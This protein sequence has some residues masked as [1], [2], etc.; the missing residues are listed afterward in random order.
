MVAT[1][2]NGHAPVLY[3][4]MGNAISSTGVVLPAGAQPARQEN[5]WD[6]VGRVGTNI[7]SGYITG[8]EYN[9]DL[10]GLKAI[11]TYDKMWR[12]DGQVHSSVTVYTLPLLRAEW[13]VKPASEGPIDVA[14]AQKVQDN[15]MGGLDVPWEDLLW[16]L[17]TGMYVYGFELREKVW[18]EPDEEGLIMLKKLAPRLQK[19]I[20]RWYPDEHDELASV[21][22]RAWRPGKPDAEGKV[23]SG[24]FTPVTIPAEKLALFTLN[25]IGNNFQGISLLRSA[26]T[27]WFYK[28]KLMYLDGIRIERGQGIPT[29][30]APAN[31]NKPDMDRAAEAL[32]SYHAH[33]KNYLLFP[34]GWSVQ[35]LGMGSASTVNPKV[36][37]DYHDLQIARAVLAQFLNLSGGGSQALSRDHS[38]FF[39]M[40]LQSV[41]QTVKSTVNKQVIRP[42]VDLNWEVQRYPTLEVTNLDSRDLDEMGGSLSNLASAGLLTPSREVENAIRKTL[43]F[44]DLEDG[45]WEAAHPPLPQPGAAPGMP[46]A[47]PPG[48]IGAAGSGYEWEAPVVDT[49]SEGQESEVSPEELAREG[50]D[51]FAPPPEV[52]LPE[53]MLPLSEIR[54]TVTKLQEQVRKLAEVGT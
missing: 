35:I 9:P 47:Q 5:Y 40:S 42:I 43:G 25:R 54:A 37:I 16:Q 23:L 51:P 30:I 27:H 28:S 2:T 17:L 10:Q 1:Y 14:I 15:L 18:A 53:D 49:D 48:D 46:V 50:F 22:Q 44:P 31:A 8:E 26:Y 45:E 32:M 52:L 38:S 3:D 33:E 24:D 41:A 13:S 7:F 12:S 4:H 29:A 11:Q 34:P 39:L 6:E 19:T 36:S 21:E 20:W